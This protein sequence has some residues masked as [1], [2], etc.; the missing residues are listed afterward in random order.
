MPRVSCILLLTLLASQA[1]AAQ[2][3]PSRE[4]ACLAPEH[5]QFDFWIGEWDVQLPN[6]KP[7]GINR[8]EP[9]LGGCALQESWTGVGGLAGH[10]YNVY[11][12]SRKL[13]HQTW[14]DA[15]GSLLQLEGGF[16]ENRMTLQGETRDSAGAPVKNRITW[17]PGGPDRLRQLWEVSTDGGKTW[18]VAFDGRYVKR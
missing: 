2:G 3:S 13:W 5:R 11:D 1:A 16:A 18:S 9:I 10:S 8:I 4:A 12:R 6:G 17:T 14:V 7:A 15:Q